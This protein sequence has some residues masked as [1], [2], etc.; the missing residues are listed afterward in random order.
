MA[1]LLLVAGLAGCSDSDRAVRRTAATVGD[2]EISQAQ[3]LDLMEGQLRYAELS[4]AAAEK[5]AKA[6]ADDPSLQSQAEQARAAAD[7]LADRYGGTGAAAGTDS[8]GT[9]G[10]AEVLS[11]AIQAELLREAA[12]QADVEV[13]ASAVRDA[14]AA[15]VENLKTQGVTSTKGLGPLLDL[16]GELQAYQT[17][18]TQAFATTGPERDA[19]LQAAFAEALPQQSQYCLNLISTP[20]EASAQ[21]AYA[22]VQ[23]GEDFIAVGNEVSVDKDTLAEGQELCITGTQLFGV[24]TDAPATLAE[25]TVLAPVDGQGSWIFVRVLTAQVPTFDQLR[26]QLE[27]ST[28]DDAATAKLQEAVA[29]AQEQLDVTVDPRFGTWNAETGV[30]DPPGPEPTGTTSTSTTDPAATDPAATDPAGS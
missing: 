1:A 23:A 27:Q 21:A 18:L 24:F 6:S 26:P 7:E 10:A 22:R 14:R 29:E 28:P 19:Q 2:A 16:Y 4:T 9:T 5:A 11:T 25:G 12:R 20:D 17:A 8:F 13:A 30:V 15:I 3:V